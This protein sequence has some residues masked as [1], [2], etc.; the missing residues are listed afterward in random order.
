[1]VTILPGPHWVLPDSI[2]HN[3]MPAAESD[4]IPVPIRLIIPAWLWGTKSG[5][6]ILDIGY[7]IVDENLIGA[8]RT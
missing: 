3:R 1:M 4:K 7:W 2:Y 6:L 8:V 5:A